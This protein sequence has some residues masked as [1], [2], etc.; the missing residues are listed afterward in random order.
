MTMWLIF[1]G[2]GQLGRSLQN[3]LKRDGLSYTALGRQDVDITQMKQVSE[4]V[5]EISPTVIV[6]AAAWTTVD[7]AEENEDD[8]YSVNCLGAGNVAVIA[9]ARATALF[10]ISTDYV[11]SGVSSTPFGEDDVPSPVSAYGRTKRAGE[12]AV[13]LAHLNGTRIVRTAWLYS[14]F[15]HNFAKTMVRKALAQQPVRVVNDQR[16][17]PTLATDLGSHLVDLVAADA[18]AGIY[19]GTNS[20]ECTWYDFATEIFRLAG[21]DPSL[22][23]AVPS[24]EY[25]TKATRPSYSVLSH[26]NTVRAHVAP[27]RPWLEALTEA[28]PHII[29]SIDQD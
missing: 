14:E 19:H 16:G 5:Q 17:Q 23:T 2:D 20:G 26:A 3:C 15:G 8:A 28:M 29:A 21:S 13:Q 10:H 9:A 25:P 22:V 12:S 7:A 4:A 11:F 6:N 18:P 24:S 27:M 1:G